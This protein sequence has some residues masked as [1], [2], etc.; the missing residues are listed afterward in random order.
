MMKKLWVTL[1]LLLVVCTSRTEAQ[2][3]VIPVV[4]TFKDS[5]VPEEIWHYK[6]FGNAIKLVKIEVF[7]KHGQMAKSGKFKDGKLHGK[8]TEWY[9]NGQKEKEGNYKES[10]EDGKWTHWRE[11]GE[12]WK[13][14]MYDNGELT[15]INRY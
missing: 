3:S 1:P 6:K 12:I 4:K 7:Y 10:Y 5:N 15:K 8:W 11:N 14:E 13:V 9:E 2:Q